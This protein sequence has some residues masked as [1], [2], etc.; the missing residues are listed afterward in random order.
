MSMFVAGLLYDGAAEPDE[1]VEN[2]AAGPATG[3][4]IRVELVAPRTGVCRM[5][6]RPADGDSIAWRGNRVPVFNGDVVWQ[7][8]AWSAP[9]ENPTY[10]TKRGTR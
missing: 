3:G 9:L 8:F 6:A 4:R 1:W 10:E 5:V 7:D 2:A